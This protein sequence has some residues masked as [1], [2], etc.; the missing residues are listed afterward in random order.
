[1]PQPLA[2]MHALYVAPVHLT[3]KYA[4]YWTRTMCTL[5]SIPRRVY[6]TGL[7]SPS[8]LTSIIKIG[9]YHVASLL[10][11]ISHSYCYCY[12]YYSYCFIPVLHT[13]AICLLIWFLLTSHYSGYAVE[14]ACA[15]LI[16]PV[17]K[18]PDGSLPK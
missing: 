12:C 2:M 9:E 3:L 8:H 14:C 7:K 10:G 6:A 4:I 13:T 16:C 15:K 5:S 18:K 11:E 1:M 17:V